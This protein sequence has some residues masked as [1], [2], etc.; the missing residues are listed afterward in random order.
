MAW[1]VGDSFDFHGA[2]A[3]MAVAGAIWSTVNGGNIWTGTPQTRFGVGVS[4]DISNNGADVLVTNTFG[5]DTTIY[6][7]FAFNHQNALTGTTGVEMGFALRDTTNKQVG[8]YWLNNGNVIVTSGAF[9]GTI[10]GTWTGA[11]AAAQWNHYQIKVVI[12]NTTG[13]VEIRKNGNTSDDFSVTSIN[14]RNGSTNNY[15]NNVSFYGNNGALYLDD[16]YVFNDQG[17]QP[18]TWQGDVRAVQ[19]MPNSDNSV[20]W[21]K[22]TGASNNACV[23]ELQENG[24]TNYVST[25]T[26][27]N[28]DLYG[29]A[30][31]S[32]TPN[33]IINVVLKSMVR[34]DDAGPHTYKNRLSSGG[35]TSDGSNLSL[36]STYQW[37]WTNYL[38]DPH[39]SAAWTASGVNAALIGPFD[40]A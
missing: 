24:D 13:S 11:Y 32:T 15:A 30:G 40:V 7:N 8:I 29:T 35:T 5:N 31:L 26:V 22:S 16:F 21:T 12:N 2:M 37:N 10:L 18:N 17:A 20:T 6:V 9:N 25:N 33:A 28:V 4:K 23:N 1:E 39:T 19:L 38:T 36:T 27:S 3:D 14:T 34:M